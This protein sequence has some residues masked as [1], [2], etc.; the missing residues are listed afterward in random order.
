MKTV[1]LALIFL[2]SIRLSAECHQTQPEILIGCTYNCDSFYNFALKKNARRLGY[3]IKTINLS[4]V[5]FDLAALDA[6]LIPGGADINPELYYPS[7]PEELV[8]YTK[9]HIDLVNLDAEGALRDPI[10]HG[11]VKKYL[12]SEELKSTPLLGICRGMQMMAVAS[13]LPLYVDIR[14]ELGIRNRYN[15]ID[16]VYVTD[17]ESLMADFYPSGKTLGVKYHHQGIRVEYFKENEDQFPNLKIGAYSHNGNIAESLE[18]LNRPAIGI[19]YHPEK[20]IFP[21]NG[22]P[23]WKWFLN[24]ACEKSNSRNVN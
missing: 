22:R 20:A 15:K 19:Q 7:I 10:E 14:H 1:F 23:I 5:N 6:I 13:G 9:K 3:K 21:S 2:F 4:K 11:V 16:R 18:F 8:T 24:K 12:S 17:T